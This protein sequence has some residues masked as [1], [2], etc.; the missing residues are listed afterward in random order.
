MSKH[1]SRASRWARHGPQEERSAVGR[2][3]YRSGQWFAEVSYQVAAPEEPDAT[4]PAPEGPQV[5]VLGKFKRP[6]N[7]QMAVE[8]KARELQRRYGAALTF[9]PPSGA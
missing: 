9:L 7:A 3:Y 4:A 8:D 5:W 6:R 1:V 2:V